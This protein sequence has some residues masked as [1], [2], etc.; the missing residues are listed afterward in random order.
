MA[1]TTESSNR[2]PIPNTLWPENQC[3]PKAQSL[4]P[5]TPWRRVLG[6]GSPGNGRSTGMALARRPFVKRT[7]LYHHPRSTVL[8]ALALA[9]LLSA[10]HRTSILI[11]PSAAA[12]GDTTGLVA[13]GEYIVRNVAGCGSCHNVGHSIDGVLSGG[14]EFKDWRLGTIRSANLTPDPATG[15]GTWSDAE[16]VRAIRTG[17]RKDGRLLAP[18]MPYVWFHELSDVDAFAVARYLKSLPSVVRE[19]KQSPGI[20]FK[21]GRATFLGPEPSATETAP[22]RGPTVAYG[23]YLAQHVA[24]CGEC[25]TPRSGLQGA[26]DRSRLFAGE[27]N[28]PKDF[29]ANP[30]NLTPDSGTGLGRWSEADFLVALRTGVTPRGDSINPFMPWR[31]IRRMT[32]DDLR[33]I[34][35]YLRTV[36][37]IRNEVPRRAS[38]T[39][40]AHP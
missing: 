26:A 10:C 37:P 27:K 16:I 30:S 38:T 22:A 36:P 9:G 32:D 29:P 1:E 15:L 19:V 21:L 35:R 17:E 40:R 4:Q 28:P 33:A 31:S 20:V 5:Q 14:A 13:R 6:F 7:Q 2:R 23:E 18:V 24:M 12:L 11:P 3:E 39:G 25:H 34:Y 8:V